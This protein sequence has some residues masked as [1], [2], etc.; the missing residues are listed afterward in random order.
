MPFDAI[1]R[2][3]K[4]RWEKGIAVVRYTDATGDGKL[5]LDDWK[6]EREPTDRIG[7]EV[8]KRLKVDQI[9]LPA[10]KSSPA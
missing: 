5:V 10:G 8:E 9:E 2:L 3:N 4:R 7:D 1:T 6:F